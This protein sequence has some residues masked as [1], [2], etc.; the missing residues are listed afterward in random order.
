MTDIN[1]PFVFHS[2]ER[3]YW[4]LGAQVVSKYDEKN[5]LMAMDDCMG[6]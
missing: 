2:S 1:N 3:I 5:V 6:K 4:L